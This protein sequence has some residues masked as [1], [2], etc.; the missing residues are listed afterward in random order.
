MCILQRPCKYTLP[1]PLQLIIIYLLKCIQIGSP[2]V[3]DNQQLVP[4]ELLRK[5]YRLFAY[6]LHLFE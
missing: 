6:P 3:R 5:S 2:R 4:T 1:S